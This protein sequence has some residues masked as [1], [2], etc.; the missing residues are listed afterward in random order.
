LGSS[1]KYWANA[2]LDKI[3]LDADSTI[4]AGDVDAWNALVTFPGFDTLANDYPGDTPWTGMGYLTSVTAHKLLS[5]THDDTT[6]D[7]VVRGDVLTG[8]GATPKWAR[9]AFPASPTG[10]VL[11]ATATDVDWSSSA[12]GTAAYADTG[13]FVSALDYK[14]KQSATDTTPGYL[15]DKLTAGAGLGLLV[16][17][18]GGNESIQFSIDN[19]D[20]QDSMIDWGTGAGQVSADDVPDGATNIIPTSTQETN[21]DTAYGWGNHASAGYLTS[22][23]THDLLSATHGDTTAST[24]AR[25]DL[26]VGTGSTPKWDNLAI[27]TVGK[28]VISDGTDVG[29]SAN[30]LGTAAYAATGDFLA[31]GGKAADSDLLDGHDTAYFQVAL[32]FGIADTNKVQINSADVADNDYAKFTATGLEGRS[33]SEVLSDIGAEPAKGLDDNYVTDAQL[34]VIGNTSGTNTGDNSANSLYSGLA[35]S[36][37]DVGQQFY[38]GTTQVAI[39]RAS[40]ALTL[41]GLTLTTPEIG[42]A[43]GTS[44]DL[45]STTLYASREITVDTGGVLNIALGSAV[46]DNFTVDT[47][48]L[49]VTG[50]VGGVFI[51]DTANTFQTGGGLTINQGADDGHIAS[52]KSSDVNHGVTTIAEADTYALMQK[53]SSNLGGF[54]FCGINEDGTTIPLI[55]RGIH[56]STDPTDSVA[57]VVMRGQK[58]SAGTTVAALGNDEAVFEVQNNTTALVTVYGDGDAYFVKDVSALTFTDRP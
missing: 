49:V 33:Y 6:A 36:K 39:N 38:I 25:G 50:D 44:L 20:I 35:A 8:Q 23:T 56:G 18:V 41:A 1:L 28:V 14:L 7:T 42:V 26:I 11:I 2:Y 15:G 57:A 51:G 22:V 16:A 58:K 10:K 13:D 4:V 46:G 37:A 12:L 29:W 27:G 52:F 55:M 53:Q 5:T 3:Y 45:G 19:D 47:D 17:N 54:Q 32:T 21:W 24:V 40:A 34:V 43:T 31:A 9:L 30:A 48:K